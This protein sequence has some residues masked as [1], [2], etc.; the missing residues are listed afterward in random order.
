MIA[1]WRVVYNALRPHFGARLLA[2][3]PRGLNNDKER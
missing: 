3:Y 1:K 2:A